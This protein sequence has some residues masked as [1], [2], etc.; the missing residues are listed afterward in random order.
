VGGASINTPLLLQL[1]SLA[2]G[3]SV[4][5]ASFIAPY[6]VGMFSADTIL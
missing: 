5:S 3:H 6:V 4:V 2:A 1:L